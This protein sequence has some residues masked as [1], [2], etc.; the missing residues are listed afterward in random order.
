MGVPD[1]ANPYA[2]FVGRLVENKGIPVLLQAWQRLN[3]V[4]P[5]KI[6]GT[7]PLTELACDGRTAGVQVTGRIPHE[8][9]LQLMR[10]ASML[11]APYTWYE[12]MPMSILEAYACG[13]PVIASKLGSM[14]V[15]VKHRQTGLLFD[16]GNAQMLAQAVMWALDHASEMRQIRMAA[17][18]EF[19]LRY[20]ADSNYAHLMSVYE[21]ALRSIK[22][23][24]SCVDTATAQ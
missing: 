1:T 9:V 3:G 17:R 22:P 5:L 13:V 18:H 7:G 11:I 24:M 12:G 4:L 6:V 16:S 21:L 20:G 23:G 19:E 15:L 2:L 10:G 14:A 8:E